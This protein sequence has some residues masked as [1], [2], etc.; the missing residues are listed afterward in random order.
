MKKLIVILTICFL[1]GVIYGTVFKV[2]VTVT[3]QVTGEAEINSLYINFDEMLAKSNVR[4]E[5]KR[6]TGVADMLALA[7]T[8]PAP[9]R[10]VILKYFKMMVVTVVNDALDTSYTW[11]QVPNSLFTRAEPE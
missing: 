7:N 11:N 4:L 1:V 3:K 10:I 8:L 2:N 9:E 6:Y 5:G